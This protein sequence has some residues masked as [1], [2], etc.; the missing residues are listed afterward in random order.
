M[1]MPYAQNKGI[2]VDQPAHPQGLISAFVV[3]CLDN[4]ISVLAKSKVSRLCL[5]SEAEQ[6]CLGTPKTSFLTTRVIL[7]TS[8]KIKPYDITKPQRR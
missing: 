6:P 4:I 8:C 7:F 3:H 2:H 1:I 5:A